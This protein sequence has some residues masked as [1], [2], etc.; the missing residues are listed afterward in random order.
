LASGRWRKNFER[1]A[2]QF[3]AGSA[4]SNRSR[5]DQPRAWPERRETLVERLAMAQNST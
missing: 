5:R 4:K 2:I 3:A 1:A